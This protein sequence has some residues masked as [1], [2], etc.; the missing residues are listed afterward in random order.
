L[1]ITARWALRIF[2]LVVVAMVVYMFCA[3]LR[4]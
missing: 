4:G 3:G 2:G 1:D